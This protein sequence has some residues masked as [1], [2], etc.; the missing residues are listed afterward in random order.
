MKPA[1]NKGENEGG[2]VKR[3]ISLP[4]SLDEKL[5]AL[6]SGGGRTYS[7][8]IREAVEL[9]LKSLESRDV[10]AVYARYYSQPEPARQDRAL[11]REVSD[12]PWRHWP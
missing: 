2:A 6:I 10:E 7:G 4:K 8:T 3:A 1:R 12:L 9:Y 5:I 11:A